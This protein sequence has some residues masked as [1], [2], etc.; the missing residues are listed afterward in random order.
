MSLSARAKTFNQY[1]MSSLT[2]EAIDGFVEQEPSRGPGGL[3]P[4]GT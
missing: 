1:E 2:S 3:G 4:S